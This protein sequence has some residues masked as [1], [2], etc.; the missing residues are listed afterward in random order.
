MEKKI[1]Y[2]SAKNGYDNIYKCWFKRVYRLIKC[3]D[4][5]VNKDNIFL[6]GK[7]NK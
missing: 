7:I 1:N 2:F 4:N 3:G 5:F 6:L